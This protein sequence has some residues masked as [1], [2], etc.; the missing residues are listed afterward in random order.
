[1]CILLGGSFLSGSYEVTLQWLQTR[2]D[3]GSVLFAAIIIRFLNVST[4]FFNI[5]CAYAGL[6]VSQLAS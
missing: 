3:N 1:M 6:L 5:A 2:A 4:V